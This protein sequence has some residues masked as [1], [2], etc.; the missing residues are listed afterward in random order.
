MGDFQPADFDGHK[1]YPHKE[2]MY[3]TYRNY[4]GDRVSP[5]T[6]VKIIH[7]QFK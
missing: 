5:Q 4:Y 1:T 6:V 2:I 3:Q 7:F